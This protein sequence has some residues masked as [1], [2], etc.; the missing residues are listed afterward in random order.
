[1]KLRVGSLGH[2]VLGIVVPKLRGLYRK[3]KTVSGSLWVVFF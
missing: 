3:L 1:M 2:R